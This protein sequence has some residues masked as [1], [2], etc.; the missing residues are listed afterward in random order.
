MI[1]NWYIVGWFLFVPFLVMSL[2]IFRKIC[3]EQVTKFE[4]GL[5]FLAFIITAIGAGLIWAQ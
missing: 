2:L 4:A 1:I 5:M 3:F